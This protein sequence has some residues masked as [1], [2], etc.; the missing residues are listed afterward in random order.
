MGIAKNKGIG[1][2]SSSAGSGGSIAGKVALIAMNE[3]PA[4]P[5]NVGNKW[6]YNG[7]IYTAV[8]TSAADDGV[9]PDYNTVYL[10]DGQ[11]YFWDGTT[12]Q[13]SDESNLVHK[14]GTETITGDKDFTGKTEANTP[15]TDDISRKVATTEFVYRH[16]L[17]SHEELGVSFNGSS[18][19]GT[20]ILGATTLNFAISTDAAAG[21][22]DFKE[23]EVFQ[24]Y[25]VLVKYNSVSAKAELF[26]VEDTFEFETYKNAAGYD[27]FRMIHIFWYK[28][29]IDADGGI[30]IILSAEPKDGYKVSPAHSRNG[31]LHEWIGIGKYAICEPADTDDGQFAVRSGLYP[32]TNRSQQQYEA[33]VRTKGQRL[34]G[35]NEVTTLQLLGLVK[36]ASLDWQ[37]KIGQGNT[38]GWKEAKVKVGQ[39]D[40]NSVIINNSDWNSNLNPVID[41]CCIKVNEHW[42][43][44]ISK[45]TYSENSNYVVLTME[46]GATETTVADTTTVYIGMQ[47]TGG[48]DSVLGIDGE[49][50]GSGNIGTTRRPIL[51]LGIENLFGN[52]GARLGGCMNKVA[53]GVATFYI[54]PDPDGD[55]VYPNDS[56]DKG[57][58]AATADFG[59]TSANNLKFVDSENLD[60]DAFLPSNN[61]GGKTGDYA[62]LTGTNGRYTVF[63]GGTCNRG[64]NA[65][66]FCLVCDSAL[67][68]AYRTYGAR[69]VFIP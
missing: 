44:V 53:S 26:A 41:L 46:E 40:A 51:T 1:V 4:T 7:K 14:D 48:A 64:G 21:T 66:G 19:T 55:Y 39:T 58:T 29:E 52:C 43:K 36:Y 69:S 9:V 2:N 20:R 50:T 13:V 37:T 28:L 11:N 22:D 16:S 10:Y 32:D 15:N 61:T 25:D 67:S 65:G 60:L 27:V 12:L 23:H 68:Y 24:S 31:Q 63:F 45:E 17:K 6:F 49:N 5:Y 56:N 8:S 34:M 57:W 62:Y 30:T 42:H 35:I 59:K 38:G 47:M 3:Q 18:A 54:N 33:L